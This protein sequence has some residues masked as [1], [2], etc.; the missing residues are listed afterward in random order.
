MAEKYRVLTGDNFHAYDDDDGADDCG[1]YD[2]Q[3]EAIEAAKLIVDKSIR[4]ERR[5]CEKP[6]DPD[7][8]YDQYTS[9]GDDPVI[10][11]DTEP[12][13]SAWEYAKTR[14]A[15]IC[16]EPVPKKDNQN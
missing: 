12:H 3:E 7:E 16:R 14:C 5:C 6:T 13:F 8:L 11:P 9:F 10:S 2:T 4:W 1:S 15:E